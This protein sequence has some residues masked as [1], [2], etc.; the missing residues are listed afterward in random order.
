MPPVK[1][2]R[3]SKQRSTIITF[4]TIA[5]VVAGFA[6]Q[7]GRS[8]W[9][10][11]SV[12]SGVGAV[13]LLGVAWFLAM[14]TGLK[15]GPCPKCGKNN[16]ELSTGQFRFCEGCKEYLTGDDKDLWLADPAAL[17]AQPVFS[18]LLPERFVWPEGC[19]VCQK[20]QT[21]TVPVSITISATSK[22]LAFSAASLALGR[23]VVR[24]GGERVY[25][26]DVPHCAAHNDGAV[27]E[28]PTI[29]GIRILFRSHQYSRDFRERNN[30]GL[31]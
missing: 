7:C 14:G 6:I 11:G 15:S 5:L 2:S 12:L 22:N 30:A 9:Q 21:R 27:L 17:A 1:K 23:V 31:V 24:S 3:T 29:G 10:N 4:V 18:S 19:A 28:N 25:S 20:P 16:L 26:V 8:A 13:A